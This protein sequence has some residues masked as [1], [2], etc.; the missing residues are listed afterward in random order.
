MSAHARGP[1]ALADGDHA[2]ALVA[3]RRAA[4]VW[5]GLEAPYHVARARRLIGFACRALGDEDAAAFEL[6]AARAAFVA[7]SAASD[8]AG[9]DSHSAAVRPCS[10][11]ASSRCCACSP[12]EPRTRRSLPI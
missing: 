2:A 9:F 11:L 7:L 3:L 5:Q 12:P 10:R 8:L 6:E 4:H 1:L